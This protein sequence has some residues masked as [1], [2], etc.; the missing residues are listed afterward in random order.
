MFI[1]SKPRTSHDLVTLSKL[2]S[3]NNK[4]VYSGRVIGMYSP[5]SIQRMVE[6]RQGK[7]T[8][9]VGLVVQINLYQAESYT[10][11][12]PIYDPEG[13]EG[14]LAQHIEFVPREACV[15]TFPNTDLT[16]ITSSE[17]SYGPSRRVKFNCTVGSQVTLYASNEFKLRY[18]FDNE[19]KKVIFSKRMPAGPRRVW[20]TP[21]DAY[22]L[23]EQ[24]VE[25]AKAE[26]AFRF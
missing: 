1:E 11:R 19:G 23:S 14:A 17:I 8:N 5:S 20:Y 15:F 6:E 7:D 18:R 26:M 3:A 2:A 24:S 16:G 25:I 12:M 22:F 13:F 10:D 4:L 21:Q 9:L